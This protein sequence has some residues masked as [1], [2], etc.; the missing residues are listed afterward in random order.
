MTIVRWFHVAAG[1]LALLTGPVAMLAAKGGPLHIRSGRL[2]LWLMFAVAASGLALA[3]SVSSRFLTGLAVL[4]FHLAYTGARGF[5]KAPGRSP[6]D[7]IV[8]AMLL[9]GGLLV[10][11][12]AVG[13]RGEHWVFSPVGLAFAGAIVALAV[14]DA[15]RWLR[16][17][18]AAD[19][20]VGGHLVR[21]LS[22]YLSAVTAFAV[23]VLDPLPGWVRWLGPGVI[24][25]I[26]ITAWALY[27]AAH[28]PVYGAAA[29]DPRPK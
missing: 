15:I 1:G 2:Y 27:V 25:G 24:G 29:S 12:S 9:A 21:M 8:V 26:G 7:G 28:P 5:R 11:S 17:R 4:S 10:A 20:G 23:T 19:G 3:V 13:R 18:R 16:P 14:V 22:S 6:A